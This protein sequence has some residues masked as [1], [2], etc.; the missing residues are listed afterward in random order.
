M[1]LSARTG[2]GIDQLVELLADRLPRPR[3]EVDVVVPYSRGDLV[4]RVHT[5]GEVL[6]EQHTGEGT[7]LHAH[8]GHA[9]AA[10]LRTVAVPSLAD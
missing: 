8:V 2:E 1:A 7:R 3:V 6:A 10:E 4:H 9:L 5:D